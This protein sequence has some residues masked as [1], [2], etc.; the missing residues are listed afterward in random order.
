MIARFVLTL[1]KVCKARVSRSFESRMAEDLRLSP[2][3]LD[4]NSTYSDLD[5]GTRTLSV[6]PSDSPFPSQLLQ[7]KTE[8][9]GL[10]EP[11]TS[12]LSRNQ[13]SPIPKTEESPSR[14]RWF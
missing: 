3:T 4:S 13:A 9:S 1:Y 11:V 7:T 8:S 2:P 10:P 14:E 5:I 6:W 12:I